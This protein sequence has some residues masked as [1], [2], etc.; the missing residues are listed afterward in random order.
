MTFFWFPVILI[1]AI[2]LLMEAGRRFGI[3]WRSRTREDSLGGSGTVEAAV[4]GLM[5]LLIAFTFYGAETRFETR[6]SLIVDEANAIATAYLRLDLLPEDAQPELREN[7]REYVKS[8]LAIYQKIPDWE[9][10]EALKSELTHSTSL[11]RQIWKH[12]VAASKLASSPS[13]QTLVVPSID[14]MIDIATIQTVALQRH[15]PAAVWGML[16]LTLLV[17]CLLAGYSMSGSRTRNWVHI[18]AFCLLFSAVIYVNVDFEYP[19]MRG[20]IRIDEMDRLL[21]QTLEDM[22]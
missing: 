11:Q 4:F 15:P 12:A 18:V 9:A 7:F 10:M 6:R 14:R 13:V 5:G 2:L 19:R 20:F 22:K 1:V 17:S 21:V 3:R 8:R 16:A